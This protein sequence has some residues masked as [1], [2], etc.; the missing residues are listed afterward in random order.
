MGNVN[1]PEISYSRG[2]L[3]FTSINLP[4]LAYLSKSEEDFF[5]KLQYEM[6]VVK[7]QLLERFEIQC[8]RKVK[9]MPFLM[10]Q[11]VWLDS[12]KLKSDDEV[13][14]VLK[15]GT[16]AIGFVGLAEC[17][18]VLYGHHHGEGE[19]YEKKALEIVRFMRNYTDKFTE[20]T[21]LNF[22]LLATPAESLAGRFLEIDRKE[23]GVIPGMTDKDFYTNSFHIPVNFNITIFDKI[24]LEAPF[25]E[26]TNGGHI[27]YVE[28][29]GD[30]SSNIDVIEK[31]VRY[32]A[33][34][35]IG[36]GSINH[37]VDRDPVCGYTGVINDECPNCHRHET[38]DEHF[39]RI[40][41]ITGYLVGDLSKWNNGKRAEESMRVKHGINY[42]LALEFEDE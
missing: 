1:G 23:F 4:R 14:E 31:I 34:C 6:E 32:M 24:K 22:G 9:N 2:N 10:G 25:H 41:R 11:G 15:H 30:T 38:A 33:E 42:D 35:G 12:D 29:D 17:M 39:E 3:S 7:S 37:P 21:H 27:T 13:R 20:D 19:E 8:K 5:D 36:Y 40:R 28:L 16:L 26:L 18:T